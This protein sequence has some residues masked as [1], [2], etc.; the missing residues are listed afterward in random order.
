MAEHKDKVKQGRLRYARWL[1]A[2]PMSEAQRLEAFEGQTHI[3][4]ERIFDLSG[5]MEWLD[6]E[7]K[8]LE[9]FRPLPL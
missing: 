7:E 1:M 6:L 4:N 2:N 3:V 5:P 9:F 8:V